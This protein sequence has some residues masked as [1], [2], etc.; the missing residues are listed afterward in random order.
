MQNGGFEEP[1][2]KIR[3]TKEFGGDP[4]NGGVKSL[5]KAFN[6]SVGTGG[7][8]VTA[9]LTN[10]I[11]H[12]GAQSIFVKFDNV[13]RSYQSAVL[14]TALVP[15]MQTSNYRIGF[16]GRVDKKFPLI[17]SERPAYMKL[18]V[19]FFKDDGVTMVGDGE[20][21]IQSLPGAKDR[22]PLFTPEKWTE[23]FFE[24]TT[25]VEAAFFVFKFSVESGSNPGKTSGI[26]FFDDITIN[27]ESSPLKT[28]KPAPEETPEMVPSAAEATPAN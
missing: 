14:E 11:A 25:P 19:E 7:G 9:G 10:E 26:I 6:V 15:V 22:P 20:F 12:T 16:W 4:V 28:P 1:A 5:W 27:G 21:K 18:Q 2:V 13:A 24:V 8:M 23:Y 3:S 17:L